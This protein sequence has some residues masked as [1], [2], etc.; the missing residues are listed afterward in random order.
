MIRAVLAAVLLA[1]SLA[2]GGSGAEPRS[3]PAP[4]APPGGL[5][6][7]FGTHDLG[8]EVGATPQ[9]RAQGLMF[10]R[11]LDRDAGMLFLFPRRA[12]GG[13]WMKN[14]LIPLS[15]AFMTRTGP[16]TYRVTSVLDMQP[17]RTQACPNYVPREPFDAA[18]EASLG[19]FA[20]RDVGPGTVV[21]VVHGT[22]PKAA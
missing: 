8:A 1:G 15:I 22:E 2:C 21:E 7:R 14:T 13:F 4:T 17:C 12:R 18:V 19:W 20:G 10:R 5:V 9:A 3:T 16:G 11:S 6:L